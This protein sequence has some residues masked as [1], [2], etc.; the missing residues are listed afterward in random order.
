M[1]PLR[2]TTLGYDVKRKLGD[3]CAARAVMRR[4]WRKNRR[5]RS[6]RPSSRL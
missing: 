1:L 3:L 6:Q 5:G 2:S 4:R